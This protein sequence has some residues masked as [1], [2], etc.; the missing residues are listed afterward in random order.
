MQLEADSADNTLARYSPAQEQVRMSTDNGGR[1]ATMSDLVRSSASNEGGDGVRTRVFLVRQPPRSVRL[2]DAP[3]PLPVRLAIGVIVGIGTIVVAWLMGTLGMR[4]GFAP[5][6]HLPGLDL[7]IVD[8]LAAA[9]GLLISVPGTI[10][11]TGIEH[12][13]LMMLCYALIA[14]PAG[15]LAGVRAATPGGPKPHVLSTVFAYGVAIVCMLQSVL[16][17]W[18]V[19]SSFRAE[20]ISPLPLDAGEVAAWFT[21]IRVAAGLDVLAFTIAA[22]WVVLIMRVA[23]PLWLRALCAPA[24][25]I[26]MIVMMVALSITNVTAAQVQAPRSVMLDRSEGESP[27]LLIGPVDGHMVVLSQAGGE[28]V[29][30][31]ESPPP[32]VRVTGQHSIIRF[33]TGK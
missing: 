7:T 16:L 9:V 3:N 10:I 24:A 2:S 17:I 13:L 30:E 5:L 31:L 21:S 14:L 20:L 28:I 26:A 6:V 18:W 8:G 4:L 33:I 32:A 15:S 27:R 19:V 22:L 1:T 11:R 29:I 12:P 23:I 25:F